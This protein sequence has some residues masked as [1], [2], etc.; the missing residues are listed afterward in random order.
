MENTA[1]QAVSVII[2][3]LIASIGLFYLGSTTQNYLDMVETSMNFDLKVRGILFD[4]YS[5][6]LAEITVLFLIDNQNSPKEV[7]LF[8]SVALQLLLGDSMKLGSHSYNYSIPPHT[9]I[10]GRW[11]FLLNNSTEIA[12]VKMLIET[13]TPVMLKM[14]VSA[15]LTEFKKVLYV[16]KVEGVE[17]QYA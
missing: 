15:V 11:S 16:N 3:F 10:V 8:T 4:Q 13:E 2:L 7:V 17:I 5:D 6:N 9:M 14:T 12:T 1:N